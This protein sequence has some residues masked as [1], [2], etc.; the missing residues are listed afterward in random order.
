MIGGRLLFRRRCIFYRSHGIEACLL[1]I[2]KGVIEC[3]QLRTN[4]VLA[5]TLV[6]NDNV[7]ERLLGRKLPRRDGQCSRGFERGAGRD[8]SAVSRRRPVFSQARR[9]SEAGGPGG[10]PNRKN[11][12]RR[13]AQIYN[14]SRIGPQPFFKVLD[15]HDPLKSILAVNQDFLGIYD[16]D[17]RALFVDEQAINRATIRLYWGVIGLVSQWLGCDG[18]DCCRT[19]TRTCARL[20]P[21]WRRY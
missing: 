7:I 11:G 4:V 14:Q 20:H 12:F 5:V 21:T 8:G 2:T 6:P 17:S 10:C 19:D 9:Y 16:Y 15:Q 1:L 13:A 18:F 3:L